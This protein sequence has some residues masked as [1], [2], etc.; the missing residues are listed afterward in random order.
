MVLTEVLQDKVWLPPLTRVDLL[1]QLSVVFS[2]VAQSLGA[3]VLVELESRDMS[4][5]VVAGLVVDNIEEPLIP[6]PADSIAS[7]MI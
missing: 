5:P 2:A 1:G 4:A 3:E 7:T 6:V